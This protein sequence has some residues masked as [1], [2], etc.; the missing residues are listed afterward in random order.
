MDVFSAALSF[1]QAH[2]V[3]SL[4]GLISLPFLRRLAVGPVKAAVKF[5]INWLF[6]RFYVDQTGA[7]VISE[8]L[9]KNARSFGLSCNNYEFDR[10]YIRPRAKIGTVWY[11]NVNTYHRVFWFGWRPIWYVPSQLDENDK[12][13][14]HS[15]CFRFLRG[16]INWERLLEL[17]GLRYD[18]R[19]AEYNGKLKFFR[20]VKHVGSKAR[21][22]EAPSSEPAT[23]ASSHN[24]GLIR[25]FGTNNLKYPLIWTND[26]LGFDGNGPDIDL[27]AITPGMDRVIKDLEFFTEGEEW[28]EERSIPWRRGYLLY[29]KPGTGKTSLVRAVAEKFDF[30]IHIFNLATMDDHDF[31]RAWTIASKDFRRIVLLEDFDTIF[32]GRE[33][34]Q[35]TSRLSFETIL[36]CVD[37]IERN[38]GLVLFV[39]TNHVDKI[40][41]AL[42][43]PDADGESSRPGRIDLIAEMTTLDHAGR[44]KVASRIVRDAARAEELVSQNV[45]ETAAQLINRCIK[46]SLVDF[47]REKGS[48]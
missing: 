23:K 12:D 25:E 44:L 26:Q 34:V 37:G 32:H 48:L 10:E 11:H 45:D 43:A 22:N 18:D 16:T 1:A 38:S 42:G 19:V 8:F 47:W 20:V 15:P 36:N 5:A 3:F 14:R 41:E 46:A 30:P 29:G 40:D 27:L 33:N 21:E 39:T 2:P 13:V 7:G 6:P 9:H 31:I 17:V 35:P 24:D 4:G 28:Y